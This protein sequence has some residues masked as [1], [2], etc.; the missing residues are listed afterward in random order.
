MTLLRRGNKGNLGI[1]YGMT[2]VLDHG[3]P[4]GWIEGGQLG[5][6]QRPGPGGLAR[7]DWFTLQL[8]LADAG[9][10]LWNLSMKLL[11]LEGKMIEGFEAKG[12]PLPPEFVA[13]DPLYGGVSLGWQQA[14]QDYI[15]KNAGVTDLLVDDFTLIGE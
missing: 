8:T 7:T 4:T 9:G 2:T 1:W 5:L 11:N 14:S 15:L 10:G 13:G 12:I 3:R 6:A